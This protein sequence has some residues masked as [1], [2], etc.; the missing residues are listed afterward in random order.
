MSSS[1]RENQCF[2]TSRSFAATAS[3]K[4]V[5]PGIMQ[6]AD[7]KAGVSDLLYCLSNFDLGVWS[8]ERK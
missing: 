8:L 6:A 3:A 4:D 7:F 1:W 5:D 2:H